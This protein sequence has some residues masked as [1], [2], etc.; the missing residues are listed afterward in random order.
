M[1][2]LIKLLLV[3]LIIILTFDIL[4]L[5]NLF[6]QFS[7]TLLNMTLKGNDKKDILF[8]R[9]ILFAKVILILMFLGLSLYFYYHGNESMTLVL[10]ILA[11]LFSI[12]SFVISPDSIIYGIDNSAIFSNGYDFI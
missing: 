2:G 4:G 7:E 11:Q 6:F 3:F 8:Y 1:G 9:E 12:S 5:I 10:L